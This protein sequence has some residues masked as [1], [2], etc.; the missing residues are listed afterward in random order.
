MKHVLKQYNRYKAIL[1]TLVTVFI[2]LLMVCC[3]TGDINLTSVPEVIILL[4]CFISCSFF[5]TKI[6]TEEPEY[7]CTGK[8]V[9]KGYELRK[10]KA[11]R[12][13]VISVEDELWERKYFSGYDELDYIGKEFINIGDSVDVFAIKR[14]PNMI[15]KSE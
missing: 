13:Y 14:H 5:L 3:I 1:Y 10:R 12:Y 6:A 2:G 15:V 9:D 4:A 8:V 11:V 7:I